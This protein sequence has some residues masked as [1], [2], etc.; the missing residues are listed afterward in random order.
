M[1]EKGS[2]SKKNIIVI[3]VIIVVLVA[4]AY[5][6]FHRDNSS[7]ALLT[8]GNT[9]T[10]DND[11]LNA[12]HQLRSLKLDNS[13]FSNPVW[14]SLGDFG[15]VISPQPLGRPNPFSPLDPSVFATTTSR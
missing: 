5:F 12:L 13:I 1:K 7:D 11:L 14:L 3:G 10:V 8:T 2:I 4:A 9:T 15:K 6:Y